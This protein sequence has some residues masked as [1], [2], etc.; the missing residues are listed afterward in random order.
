LSLSLSFV[1][2]AATLAAF[3]AT[4]GGGRDRLAPGRAATG[5]SAAKDGEALAILPRDVKRPQGATENSRLQPLS[6]PARPTQ[7]S[8]SQK[9]GTRQ[10]PRNW[11]EGD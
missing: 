3:V 5:R 4:K 7:G 1:G 11:E 2:S 6:M 8:P 10:A 9:A